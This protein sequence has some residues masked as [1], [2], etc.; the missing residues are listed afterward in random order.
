LHEIRDSV[1]VITFYRTKTH[2]CKVLHS[3]LGKEDLATALVLFGRHIS[4]FD[5][6]KLAIINTEKYREGDG[7]EGLTFTPK[8][9]E[10]IEWKK[11][12]FNQI[13]QND[14]L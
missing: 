7:K 3:G 2:E 13:R 11:N 9:L 1:S 8:I 4:L 12:N 10:Y 14:I 6:F 5:F